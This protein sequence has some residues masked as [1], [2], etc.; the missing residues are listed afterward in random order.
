L[1]LIS[2]HPDLFP[3]YDGCPCPVLDEPQIYRVEVRLANGPP[4]TSLEP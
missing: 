4:D 2:L 3:R 1:L